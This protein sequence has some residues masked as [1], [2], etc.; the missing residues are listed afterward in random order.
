MLLTYHWPAR[1]ALITEYPW[2]RGDAVERSGL[3]AIQDSGPGHRHTGAAA[4]T[5]PIRGTIVRIPRCRTDM[6]VAREKDSMRDDE[7]GR[8]AGEGVD[9]PLSGDFPHDRLQGAG[10]SRKMKPAWRQES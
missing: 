6:G 10:I 7:I 9:R 4:I 8:P 5:D 3:V 2:R 1:S